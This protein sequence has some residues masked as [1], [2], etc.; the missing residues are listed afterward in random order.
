MPS[1][2]SQRSIMPAKHNL[3]LLQLDESD[4]SLHPGGQM[5]LGEHTGSIHGPGVYVGSQM[6]VQGVGNEAQG[7]EGRGRKEYMSLRVQKCLRG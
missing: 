3:G 6:L 5:K 2:H 4:K 7:R 1:D